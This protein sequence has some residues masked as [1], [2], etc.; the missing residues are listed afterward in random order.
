MAGEGDGHQAKLIDR[1]SATT[2]RLRNLFYVNLLLAG[3][4]IFLVLQDPAFVS[5]KVSPAL[6]TLQPVLKVEEAV[7][8]SDVLSF[9]YHQGLL[10]VL[11]LAE[12]T[13]QALQRTIEALPEEDQERVVEHLAR[14]LPEAQFELLEAF[15]EYP[16]F[17]A[18]RQILNT[19]FEVDLATLDYKHLA[20]LAAFLLYAEHLA[21][22]LERGREVILKADDLLPGDLPTRQQLLAQDLRLIDLRR[23]NNTVVQDT[24][25]QN[26]L[27]ELPRGEEAF[28]AVLIIDTFCVANAMANCS[29]ADIEKWQEERAGEAAGKLSAP[30]LE[31]NLARD[32]VVPASPLVLLVAYHI[33][34]LQFRRRQALRRRLLPEL[35]ATRLN[36]L[37]ETWVLNS[38]VLNMTESDGAWRKLQSLLMAVFLFVGQAAPLAAVA[39]AGYYSSKQIL[40]GVFIAEEFAATMTW[41]DNVLTGL[42]V[43]NLPESPSPPDHFWE[44]L[45]IAVAA[46]CALVLFGSLV[47]LLRD[48]V[49][50]IHEAWTAFEEF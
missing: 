24:V 44:Y 17:E 33:Y 43:E 49:K 13:A 28:R 8:A 46:L 41:L 25:L 36:L 34:A 35:S 26:H 27:L 3:A 40:I 16:R 19:F 18:D 11:A 2:L 9:N 29:V 42:G 12:A 1:L 39:V 7:K 50:E 20:G 4:V 10:K 21:A 31:V 45:W 6:A 15:V 47:Q 48:Q 37:D 38:L 32:I 5:E 22:G 30:G 23:F 14:R